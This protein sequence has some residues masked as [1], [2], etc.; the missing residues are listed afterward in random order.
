MT[1]EQFYEDVELRIAPELKAS[2]ER[3]KDILK[4]VRLMR[5]RN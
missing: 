1:E 2:L 3:H 5:Q 4:R